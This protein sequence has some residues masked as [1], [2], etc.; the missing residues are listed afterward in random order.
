[1]N[2]KTCVE[3][4]FERID[5]A[6]VE[7]VHGQPFLQIVVDPLVSGVAETAHQLL[8]LQFVLCHALLDLLR[9]GRRKLLHVNAIHQKP[10]H[11][12]GLIAR[13]QTG[14]KGAESLK[15]L[16][17]RKR[18][19]E[20]LGPDGGGRLP[21]AAAGFGGAV[22]DDAVEVQGKDAPGGFGGGGTRAAHRT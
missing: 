13:L 12:D 10:H 17:R 21:A 19:G 5:D 6:G 2:L 20:L 11:G 18:G 4:G 14:A 9:E 15:Q 16:R 22:A 1:M 7:G 3:S 8:L